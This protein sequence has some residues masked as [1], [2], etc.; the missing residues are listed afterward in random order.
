MK[1]ILTSLMIT[2]L[3]ALTVTVPQLKTEYGLATV[4]ENEQ[5]IIDKLFDL[6]DRA[7]ATLTEI[8]AKLEARGVTIP[9]EVLNNYDKGLAIAKG[10][11]Q[12]R[13]KGNYAEAKE[14]ILEAMRYLRDAT[15]AVGDDLRRVEKPEER[16]AR[17]SAGIEAAIKRIQARIE[18]LREIAEAAEARGINASRIMERLGNL[19]ELL[20]RIKG[21]IEAGNVS[22][23]AREKE[24]S[25]RWFGEA[26]AALKP[27]I[28][29]YKASQAE[30]F[31]NNTEMR[32]LRISSRINDILKGLPIPEIARNRITQHM[33]RGIQTAKSRIAD[34]RGL[35][36]LGRMNEAIQMLDELRVDIVNLMRE[37]K[38]QPSVKPEIGEALEEIDRCE[39]VLRVLEERSEILEEK[40]VNVTDLLTK[41]Q[42]ARDSI[43]KAVEK[44]KEGKLA[45]AENLLSQIENIIE[46]AKSL[47]NQ[48]ETHAS[49]P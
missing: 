21:K 42:E 10:A 36:K 25:Q 44:L 24:M 11:V 29:T 15:L 17:I 40:G 7:N 12:L 49:S 41:I 43:Q 33:G 47:T 38:Q 1:K 3:I 48:L 8:F 5:F 19:T 31:L 34:V 9:E 32:L 26:M 20:T 2:V 22:E 6:F 16:E 4:E 14:K 30:R 13:D 27:I 35:L 45:I 37:M 23:A 18:K 28:E 46:E 39:I